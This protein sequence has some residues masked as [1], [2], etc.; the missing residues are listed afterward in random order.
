[1]ITPNNV[2]CCVSQLDFQ[3]YNMLLLSLL[4][5]HLTPWQTYSID[6]VLTFLEGIRLSCLLMPEDIRTHNLYPPLSA[7]K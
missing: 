6:I 5:P 3:E 7:V 2:V 1:M 4:L